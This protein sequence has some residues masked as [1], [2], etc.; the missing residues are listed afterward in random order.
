MQERRYE[1]SR[2]SMLLLSSIKD[3]RIRAIKFQKIK[4][5]KWLVRRLKL[6]P[7]VKLKKG[8]R[9]SR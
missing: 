3:Q 9:R 5:I 7:N 8:K 1:S 6:R 2:K 4:R